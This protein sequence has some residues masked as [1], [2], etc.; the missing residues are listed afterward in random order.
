M[1]IR[2]LP[3]LIISFLLF[4]CSMNSVWAWSAKGHQVIAAIAYQQLQAKAR[5]QVNG[6]TDA[7]NGIYPATDFIQAAVWPD[8]IRARGVDAF[9]RWHYISLPYVKGNIR[10][11]AYDSQNVVWAVRQA[12]DVLQNPKANRFEQGWFL[13]FYA[14]LIGDINQPL[15]SINRYSWRF[16]KGDS[17]GKRYSIKAGKVDNLHAYWDQAADF[18]TGENADKN[19]SQLAQALQQRYPRNHFRTR[20]G[21]QE[22]K[23]WARQGHNIAKKDAYKIK[24]KSKP[25][26]SYRNRVRKLATE[27]MTLAGYRLADALNDLY[28]DKV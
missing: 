18:F 27:Q 6:L 4:F 2:K 17:G 5:V 28:G 13:R 8:E 15:H 25:K 1:N 14:H 19:P 20:L 26:A 12:R 24:Y 11:K 3:V 7:L 21:K 23:R 9:D 10:H 16:V 22:P